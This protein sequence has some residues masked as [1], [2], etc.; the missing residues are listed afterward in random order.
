MTI[1]NII[2]TTIEEFNEFLTLFEISMLKLN[3]IV[4]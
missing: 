3:E 2:I 1:R 4:F